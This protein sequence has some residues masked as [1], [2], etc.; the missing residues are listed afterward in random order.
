MFKAIHNT[1][2]G[3]VE[4]VVDFVLEEKKFEDVVGVT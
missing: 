4:R 3:C 2:N 1:Y